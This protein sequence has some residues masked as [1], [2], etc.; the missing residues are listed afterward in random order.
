VI[1]VCGG[2]E[3]PIE[4]DGNFVAKA[5]GLEELKF[6]P[7]CVTCGSSGRRKIETGNA[8]R[9]QCRNSHLSWEPLKSGFE[10]KPNG[11]IAG[12]EGRRITPK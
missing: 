10:L 6:L 3:I 5:L 8:W 12:S 11:K 1:Y 9:H 2:E 4:G 7:G